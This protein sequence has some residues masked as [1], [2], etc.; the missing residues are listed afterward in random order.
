MLD[1]DSNPA[2]VIDGVNNENITWP[3]GSA[4]NGQYTVRVNWFDACEQ[5]KANWV[6][7]I[8]VAGRAPQTVSGTL[9]PPA[10]PGSADAG[11][12]VATFSR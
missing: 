11:Q 6:V 1:L 2:C 3:S 7:T 12:V 5:A 4:P 10:T 8:R 9:A